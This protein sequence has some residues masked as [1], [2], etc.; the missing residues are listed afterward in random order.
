MALL[1]KPLLSNA[2]FLID[3]AGLGKFQVLFDID[4]HQ[5]I[6]EVGIEGELIEGN[7]LTSFFET[8][9]GQKLDD[10]YRL[11]ASQIGHEYGEIISLH[12]KR[13]IEVFRGDVVAF[14]YK[15]LI[16]RCFGVTKD[17]LLTKSKEVTTLEQITEMTN[18]CMGCRSCR[19][20]VIE[21]FLE[22]KKEKRSFL[23]IPN[24]QWVSKCD[25][26]LKT[27]FET[28]PIDFSDTA[29]QIV[30]FKSGIV[31]IKYSEHSKN[32]DSFKFS[33]EQFLSEE[34]EQKVTIFYC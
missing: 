2:K 28:T 13:M 29:A 22:A 4:K 30:S 14:N 17:E 15:N 7:E 25:E 9:I 3:E 21:T 24:A 20:D 19:D 8:L 1:K 27:F 5:V 31:K 33:F 10:V 16:C 26:L 6:N 23:D 12:L 32:R 18:A 11:N 34:L